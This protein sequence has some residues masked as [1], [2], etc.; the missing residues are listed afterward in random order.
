MSVDARYDTT[1]GTPVADEG[2]AGDA[3]HPLSADRHR[4]WATVAVVA[5]YV[6]LAVVVYW[7]AWSTGI[8]THM[9]LGGDQ[10]ANVWFLRWTPFALLHGLNPFFTTYANFPFGV[11]LVTNTSSPLLGLL[12]MPVTL[13]F[14]SI[15]TF[16]VLSTLALAGSATA[17]YVVARRWTTWRPA[18]WVAGLL[19]GFSPYQ[20]GQASGHLNLT[21]V[22]LPPL[23]LLALHEV[24]VRQV[25]S[26]RRAGVTLGLLVAAQFFVSS[27][28]L[29]ST[30]VLG[31]VCLVTV[32]VIGH[33]SLAAH[34]RRAVVGLVWAAGVA[35]V[36]LAY[37]AWYAVRGPGSISGPIQLVP[38]A[39]RADVLGLVYP[40][41]FMRIAPASLTRTSAVFANSIVENGSYL[42]ITLVVTVVVSVFVLWRRSVPVRVAAVGGGAAWI[43]SL[44]GAVVVRSAPGA[45]LTGF[46]LPERLFA[47][48]PL[49]SNTIPVRYSLYVALFASMVLA[50]ALD[51]LHRW[52]VERYPTGW[53]RTPLGSAV[54]PGVLAVVCLV[55][56][57]PAV[58]LVGFADPG[59]PAYF[60]STSIQRVPAGSVAL[61]YPFPSSATPQGELWQA[62]A[63]LRFKMPGGYFLVPQPPGR[64]IAFSPA[65]GYDT[66]TLTSRTLI[67][68]AAGT[69]PPE[70]PALHAA[71]VAQ[72]RGWHVRTLLA[73]TVGL[74][75]PAQSVRFLTW[76]AGARPEPDGGVLVW[77]HFLG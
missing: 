69:P 43:L 74:G 12:G 14:G 39:Y 63:D 16:N 71:L 5:S 10:F 42:G 61:L 38:E 18:A 1:S 7:N 13:A 36:L 73:S 44:G 34:L 49:L 57:I 9:Q 3:V 4:V 54:V 32:V 50:L 70:T 11:N 22:V 48:L 6:A 67:A 2:G 59:I 20:I 64:T 30:I 28:I 58:P 56:V 53:L 40:G 65:L 41:A 26:P 8:T 60:G 55:P 66:D 62:H 17:G 52:V 35:G 31:T 24:A 72:L 46:P 68:V 76:L 51:A 23:I 47:H 75:D 19:Y 37:P 29:A 25:W 77:Y 45:S 21:F 33:R 15:A 27:E